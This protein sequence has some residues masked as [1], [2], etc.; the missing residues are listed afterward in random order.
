MALGGEEAA[1]VNAP[2]PS[3]SSGD[4]VMEESKHENVSMES[5]GG[6]LSHDED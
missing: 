3:A 1:P 5:S 2:M 6:E 4:F